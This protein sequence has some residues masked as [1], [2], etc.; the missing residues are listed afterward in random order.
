MCNSPD[1]PSGP[2]GICHPT[3]YEMAGGHL[4]KHLMA[5]EGAGMILVD[6]PGQFLIFEQH[7]AK[8]RFSRCLKPSEAPKFLL[9]G[10][11][12]APDESSSF[13]PSPYVE[14]PR[15]WIRNRQNGVSFRFPLPP[16]GT[17]DTPMKCDLCVCQGFPFGVS[18]LL[19]RQQE[20]PAIVAGPV[21]TCQVPEASFKDPEP[22]RA[23]EEPLRGPG[24]SASRNLILGRVQTGVFL[25]GL[26]NMVGFCF[27]YNQPK[28][29]S[30]KT[31]APKS[32]TYTKCQRHAGDRAT[33]KN[34]QVPRQLPRV[35]TH[36]GRVRCRVCRVPF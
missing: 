8:R 29:G 19:G 33:L 26:P 18:V 9:A 30:Q 17:N 32:F 13:H 31:K 23:A 5:L 27:P 6:S 10:Q 3:C 4:A 12:S 28:G 11:K 16:Q 15:T 25:R 7:P 24:R 35:Q 20:H 21:L 36:L 2:N 14:R 34:R 1:I 22:A